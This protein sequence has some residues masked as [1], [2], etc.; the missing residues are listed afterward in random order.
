M[1]RYIVEALNGRPRAI[2]ALDF[3]RSGVQIIPMK[4][5]ANSLA[6]T[7]KNLQRIPG[8]GPSLSRD[9]VDLG[10]KRVSDLRGRDPERLYNRLCKVRGQHQDRCV[11]YVFRCAIYF[12]STKRH[13]PEKLKWWRWK[14]SLEN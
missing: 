14:D 4:N 13:D 2:K 1:E 3:L 7:L 11:L 9:L 10:I 6:G 12:A 8:I 5:G